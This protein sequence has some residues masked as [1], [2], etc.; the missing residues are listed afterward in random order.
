LTDLLSL[1]DMTF[2]ARFDSSAVIRIG[3]DRLVR[4]A[5]FAAGNSGAADFVPALDHL[6]RTDRSELVREAAEW[7]RLRLSTA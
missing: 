7:A 1:D 2:N 6:A 3:R 5:C 4:N